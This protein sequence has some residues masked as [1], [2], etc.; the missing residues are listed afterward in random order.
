MKTFQIVVR[1]IEHLFI[2]TYVVQAPNIGTAIKTVKKMW[3][4][5]H[6]EHRYRPK[7]YAWNEIVDAQPARK[8]SCTPVQPKV[9]KLPKQTENPTVPVMFKPAKPSQSEDTGSGMFITVDGKKI[10]LS[11]IPKSEY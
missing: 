6:P 11:L 1:D 2:D 10:E 4:T 3:D 8:V 7:S 9:S 5:A